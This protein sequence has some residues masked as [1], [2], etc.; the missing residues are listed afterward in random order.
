MVIFSG[1]TSVLLSPLIFWLDSDYFRHDLYCLFGSKSYDE[2]DDKVV[3]NG[4]AINSFGETFLAFLVFI[5][6]LPL[7]LHLSNFTAKLLIR[8]TLNFLSNSPNSPAIG[9]QM[10]QSQPVQQNNVGYSLNVNNGAYR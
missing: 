7:T 4:W 5:P 8:I 6:T 9:N 10:Q 2:V 1:V 3:C